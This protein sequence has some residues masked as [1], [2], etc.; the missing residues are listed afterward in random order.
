MTKLKFKWIY[1]NCLMGEKQRYSS[2]IFKQHL[3]ALLVI[4]DINSF[5]L[6]M[7]TVGTDME[8]TII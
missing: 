7:F 1:Y 8:W 4:D 5:F 6:K 2:D 3:H